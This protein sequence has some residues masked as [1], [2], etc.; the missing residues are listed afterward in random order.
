M[1][2]RAFLIKSRRSSQRSGSSNPATIKAIKNSKDWKRSK[3][4][5]KMISQKF[6]KLLENSERRKMTRHSLK[7]C[8]SSQNSARSTRNLGESRTWLFLKRTRWLTLINQQVRNSCRGDSVA[9]QA[10]TGL[11]RTKTTSSNFRSPTTSTSK[12]KSRILK[13][14]KRLCSWW[15]S[16]TRPSTRF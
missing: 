2:T 4:I 14:T 3:P 15:T 8:S 9:V 13:I 5:C 6:R 12:L 10:E 11:L 7:F 1:T 16:L